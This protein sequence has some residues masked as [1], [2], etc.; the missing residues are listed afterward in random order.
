MSAEA[1]LNNA[2]QDGEIQVMHWDTSLTRDEDTGVGEEAACGT[3][4][5]KWCR[6]FL[7][8]ASAL[9]LSCPGMWTAENQKSNLAAK[10]TKSLT[11]CIMCKSLQKMELRTET[12]TTLSTTNRIDFPDQDLPKVAA[13]NTTG[14]SSFTAIERWRSRGGHSSWSHW[15][16]CTAPQPHEPEASE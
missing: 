7:D 4:E 9:E 12:T 6:Q 16:S 5:K 10:N 13:A 15:S 14:I 3:A 8:M 2:I 11:R 1:S